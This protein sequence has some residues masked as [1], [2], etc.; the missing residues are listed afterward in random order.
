MH[1]ADRALA[2]ALADGEE[3]LADGAVA[4]AL[5]DGALAEALADDDAIGADADAAGDG[6]GGD[7]GPAHP[8]A[9]RIAGIEARPTPRRVI[10]PT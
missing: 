8:V 9:T 7:G 10:A 4:E 1:T 6:A 2:E 5:A 3:A